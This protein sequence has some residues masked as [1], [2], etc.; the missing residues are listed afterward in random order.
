MNLKFLLLREAQKNK[1]SHW[2]GSDL[3]GSNTAEAEEDTDPSKEAEDCSCWVTAEGVSVVGM[4]AVVLITSEITPPWD[5][6]LRSCWQLML[7]QN[8]YSCVHQME[9]VSGKNDLCKKNNSEYW[10]LVYSRLWHF[11]PDTVWLTTE[12]DVVAEV[13]FVAPAGVALG[14]WR[15]K[16]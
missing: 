5:I 4:S 11:L 9:N 7:N 1:H 15:I 2:E 6:N 13:G 8:V 16:M 10:V 12:A 14:I 3:I